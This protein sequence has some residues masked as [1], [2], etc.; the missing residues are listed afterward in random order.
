MTIL[1]VDNNILKHSAKNPSY[2]NSSNRNAYVFNSRNGLSYYSAGIVPGAPSIEVD[3]PTLF[4]KLTNS[5]DDG[6]GVD[7]IGSN[8]LTLYGVTAG[9]GKVGESL[10]YDG[11]DYSIS[12]KTLNFASCSVS[13][14]VNITR[15][16]TLEVLVDSNSSWTNPTFFII[17]NNSGDL[18]VKF[19]N[20]GSSYELSH[21][22]TLGWHFISAVSDG[23]AYYYY[24]DGA[25][26]STLTGTGNATTNVL[27]YGS[28]R[29]G[30]NDLYFI[31][32]MNEIM[33]GSAITLADHQYMYNYGNG[34]QLKAV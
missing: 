24:V 15:T 21:T 8:D 27:K 5:Y 2:Y 32:D 19:L 14:W 6:T 9:T 4:A 3:N 20:N 12:T 25:L 18:Q 7:V 28:R 33:I 13:M 10:Y 23:S 17:W 22:I 30:F 11:N 31:G 29:E 1:S 26:V 16:S 34:I